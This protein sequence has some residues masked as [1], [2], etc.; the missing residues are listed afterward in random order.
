[1]ETKNLSP[2]RKDLR[3]K[4]FDYSLPYVYFITIC[5]YEK[6]IFSSITRLIKK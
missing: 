6:E 3:L 1:M 2:K 4:E 5:T